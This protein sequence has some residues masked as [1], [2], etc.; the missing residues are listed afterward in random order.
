ME[1]A[2]TFCE[3]ADPRQKVMHWLKIG[4]LNWI[5]WCNWIDENWIGYKFLCISFKLHLRCYLPF[6]NMVVKREM[7]SSSEQQ[8]AE[9][10]LAKARRRFVDAHHSMPLAEQAT[11]K[12]TAWAFAEQAWAQNATTAPQATVEKLPNGQTWEDFQMKTLKYAQEHLK[13]W[14]NVC[15]REEMQLQAHRDGNRRVRELQ[16]EEVKKHGM[17][18][19]H[20]DPD[21]DIDRLHIK[22]WTP[23]RQP[24][25]YF[26]CFLDSKLA[27]TIAKLKKKTGASRCRAYDFQG[28]KNVLQWKRAG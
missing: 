7:D 25:H 28:Y 19:G 20:I 4:W 11:A 23:D 12:A 24:H 21:P 3:L 14:G 10:Q 5:G 18:I 13:Y 27:D 6:T 8:P 17:V 26:I 15:Q 1:C 16:L 22:V 2:I 9:E